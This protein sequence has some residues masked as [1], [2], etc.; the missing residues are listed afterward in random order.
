LR[1]L[2]LDEILTPLEEPDHVKVQFKRKN[3]NAKIRLLG[4]V[5]LFSACSKGDLAR[6][7]SLV[8]EVEV[9]E[10]QVLI[11]QGEPGHECFIVVSGRAK[12]A[13]RGRRS[14]TLGPGSFFGE[15]ALLDQGPRTRTITAESGMHL[16]VLDS[17]SFSSLIEDV[18]GVGRR[19]LRAVAER[20]REAERSAPTH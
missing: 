16:L 14:V 3:K 5:P 12:A 7:A 6:I 20:L 15:L 8:D 10:G 17:R 1:A 11:R 19:V 13:T 18:P 9:Q 2:L 4:K